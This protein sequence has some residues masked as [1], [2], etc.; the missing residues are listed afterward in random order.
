MPSPVPELF[1]EHVHAPEFLGELVNAGGGFGDFGGI[2]MVH[3]RLA[4]QSADFFYTW[5]E[6]TRSSRIPAADH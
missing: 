6:D 4:A 2:Q 3:H 1:D 5:R